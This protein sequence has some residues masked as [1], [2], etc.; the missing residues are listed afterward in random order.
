MGSGNPAVD[1]DSVLVFDASV[2]EGT[3]SQGMRGWFA[4]QYPCSGLLMSGH[5]EPMLLSTYEGLFSDPLENPTAGILNPSPSVID[6]CFTFSRLTSTAQSRFIAG[7]HGDDTNY[8]AA[9]ITPATQPT[10]ASIVVEYQGADA[11]LADGVTIDASAPSTGWVSSPS[12]CN[13]MRHIRYRVSLTSGMSSSAIARVESI[14]IP[15]ADANP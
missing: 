12:A 14:T 6:I 9:T 4:T 8:L 3:A 5:P 7:A 13:G 2:Q 10:G 1:D 15:M 11:V